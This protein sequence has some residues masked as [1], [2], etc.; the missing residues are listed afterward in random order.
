M[1]QEPAVGKRNFKAF[2]PEIR[3][4]DEANRTIEF[5]ASTEAVDRYGDVIRVAG[6]K[7]DAYKK[8]PVFL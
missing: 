7:L 3:G 6:W 1:R 5:V 4:I 2:T 8:N